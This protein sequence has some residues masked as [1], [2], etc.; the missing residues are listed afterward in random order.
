MAAM[1]LKGVEEAMLKARDES[2]KF[3]MERLMV[4]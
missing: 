3:T 2:N 4:G 1:D